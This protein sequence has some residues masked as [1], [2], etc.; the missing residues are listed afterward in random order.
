MSFPNRDQLRKHVKRTHEKKPLRCQICLNMRL[1]NL[2]TMAHDSASESGSVKV[3]QSNSSIH[4]DNLESVNDLDLRDI[5][6][7]KKNQLKRHVAIFHDD[8]VVCKDHCRKQFK[9]KKSLQA[10]LNRVKDQAELRESKLYMFNQ[11][12][13]AGSDQQSSSSQNSYEVHSQSQANLPL[14]RSHI[15]SSQLESG[16]SPS[17]FDWERL[18]QQIDTQGLF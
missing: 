13:I 15:L 16:S 17:K 8:P 10:H 2:N 7:S 5:T 4:E 6:F 9:S 3:L 12:S 18:P 1:Q 11:H 14:L